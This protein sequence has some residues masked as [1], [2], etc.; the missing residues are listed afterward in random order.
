MNQK[1]TYILFGILGGMLSIFA[2]VLILG[3]IPIEIG[4]QV[5]TSV[6]NA[7]NP[8]R[9][10][11]INEVEI[12][13]DKG[14][15]W[16]FVKDEATHAWTIKEPRAMRANGP[17]IDSLIDQVM[18][19]KFDQTTEK[20][21]KLADW[22]LETP[23]LTVSLKRAKGKPLQLF[24]GTATSNT[25]FVLSS[26]RGKDPLVVKKNNLNKVEQD[27]L[28][29]R[30]RVMLTG[31]ESDIQSISLSETVAGKDKFS[32]VELV[33]RDQR[34]YY[35]KPYPGDAD[36]EGDTNTALAGQPPSGTQNLITDLSNIRVANDGDFIDNVSDLAKYNLDDKSAILKIKVDLVVEISKTRDVS[37]KKEED[38]D[39]DKE[40]EKPEVKTVPITLLVGVSKKVD[41]DKGDQYYARRADEKDVVK[42]D[43]KNIDPLLK[44]LEQPD[45]L[46]DRRLVRLDNFREPDAIDIDLKGGGGRLEF[47]RPDTGKAWQMYRGAKDEKVDETKVK[48]LISSL[49]ERRKDT[50]F[51]DPTKVKKDELGLDKPA[52]VVSLWVEGLV[53]EEKKD[54]KKDP[55]DILEKLDDKKPDEK[56]AGKPKL[57]SPDKP[58]IKLTFAPLKEGAA[59][60]VVMRE[61]EGEE[62]A[63][64][65][66]PAKTGT[67]NWVSEYITA[68]AL[69]YL[70]KS[71]PRF[72]TGSFTDVTKLFFKEGDKTIEVTREKP[73]APWKIVQPADLKD[74]TADKLTIEIM[75]QTLNTLRAEKLIADEPSK[76]E[77]AKYGL[78]A[79]T[80]R[81]VVTVTKD[82]K[83]TPYTF[84]FGK[85]DGAALY[86]KQSQRSGIFTVDKSVLAHFKEPLLDKT[87]FSF[88]PTKVTA[89]TLT[90]WSKVVPTGYTI[91]LEHKDGKDWVALG[92]KPT[93]PP[94]F[95]L[96]QTKVNTLVGDLSRMRAEKFLFHKSE[97]KP[98]QEL[99]VAKGALRIELKIDGEKEPLLLTIGKADMDGY[100]AVTNK[101]PGDVFLIS[102]TGIEGVVSKPTYFNKP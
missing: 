59:D 62:P 36:K 61:T 53:K 45:A 89:V 57:K 37:E 78:T 68:G 81:A 60:V 92:A 86:A 42:I 22:G 66:V 17:A 15:K 9:A 18:N 91:K 97:P 77:D 11:H 28:A 70:D 88:D 39:K 87:V 34:W 69:A 72:D 94:P 12:E 47:L 46:R 27:L 49:I 83:E 43:A 84:E 14:D 102:K 100:I 23:R 5:F 40:K 96:D 21:A 80:A 31:R 82:K 55:L 99:D 29:Y 65:R 64:L 93:D 98:E 74:R 7:V 33:K 67:V 71:L 95:E 73:E 10:D 79:P 25:V 58:T 48:G 24:L 54:A 2:L 32:P 35:T 52:A 6:K 90:G 20:P 19:S 44:L 85:E 75:L 41:K 16:V 1:T 51:I 26:D 4:D 13:R 30:D 76:D 3:P 8:I 56:K 50:T 101:L 38:K 63:Y